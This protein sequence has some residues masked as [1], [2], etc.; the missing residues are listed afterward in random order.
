MK[1]I[2][3][4]I[5]H[6][7]GEV[8][9][10]FPLFAA[11]KAKYEIDVEIIFGVKKIYNQ[12][13][14]IKFYDYCVKE[15]DIKTTCLQLPNKFDYRDSILEKFYIGKIFLK[16]YWDVL[17]IL[18]YPFL[19]F[20]LNSADA[21]MHEISNQYK[22][23]KA[24]YRKK[25]FKLI[26]SYHHGHGIIMGQKTNH[27][28]FRADEV[29][30][31]N[32]H[33]HNKNVLLE[34]GFINQKIIGYPKFFKEWK[35][36]V[37]HYNSND[38]FPKEIIVIFSRHVHPFYM[39]EDKYVKLFVKSYNVIRE[40]LGNIF[41][42]IKP[43]PRE[44]CDL[45]NKIMLEQNMINISI[46]WEHPAILLKNALLS[47]SFWGSTILDGLSSG[48]PSVEFYM[49]SQRFREVE[50]KGS[51]IKKLVYTPLTKNQS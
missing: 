17:Y 49:E 1:K 44:K 42:V 38:S 12:F 4:M 18:K 19:M 20:K 47:I 41:I 29:V 21:F 34:A 15:L 3:I 2:I 5:T 7:L 9:V 40:K 32:F 22:S 43:H 36:L 11:V 8:D 24:I 50:P 26:F 10:I 30:H 25:K 23:T 28:V 35:T 37:K 16:V 45:I 33:E 13:N 51:H 27:K 48:V 39:D 6:S 14:Y 31:L 46:S